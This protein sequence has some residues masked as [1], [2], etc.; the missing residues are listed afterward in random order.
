MSE[1]RVHEAGEVGVPSY[2]GTTV[3]HGLSN[4]PSKYN[5]VDSATILFKEHF[6]DNHPVQL[7]PYQQFAGMSSDQTNHSDRAIGLEVSLA[8]CGMM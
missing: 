6:A 4:V 8:T 1:T 7:D 3:Q 2:S 5:P